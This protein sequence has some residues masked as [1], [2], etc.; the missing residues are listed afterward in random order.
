MVGTTGFFTVGKESSTSFLLNGCVSESSVCA[1]DVM[2]ESFRLFSITPTL[3]HGAL[4]VTGDERRVTRACDT[5]LTICF[6]ELRVV[7]LKS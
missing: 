1:S 7:A 3:C 6:S 4:I 5:E 2:S